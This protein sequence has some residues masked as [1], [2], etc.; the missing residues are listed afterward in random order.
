[1]E[2]RDV[3]RLNSGI[4]PAAILL[5]LVALS[6]YVLNRA[7]R[8]PERF[9]HWHSWLLI[10]SAVELVLLIVLIGSNVARLTR[11]YRNNATGSRLSARLVATFV[12]LSVLPMSVVYYFSFDFIRRGIDSWF[13]VRVDTPHCGGA[14]SNTG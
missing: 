6:L 13:D 12:L 3:K 2:T 5:G 8:D 7:T 10:I 4:A 14:W 1:M 11:Q 9:S